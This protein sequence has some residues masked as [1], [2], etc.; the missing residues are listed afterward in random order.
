MLMALWS[1]CNHQDRYQSTVEQPATTPPTMVATVV[2][3]NPLQL[4]D[5]YR[6]VTEAA[7]L[8]ESTGARLAEDFQI[9]LGTASSPAEQ[10][11]N[12]LIYKN[13]FQGAVDD[14]VGSLESLPPP[15]ESALA[16]ERLIAS[17]E[18]V[19]DHLASLPTEQGWSSEEEKDRWQRTFDELLGRLDMACYGAL[20]SVNTDKTPTFCW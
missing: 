3:P 10:F 6:Q 18:E 11:S 15:A 9:A 2:E 12:F 8:F 14:F 20:Q 5:Y 13:G 1:A 19:R 16:H 17:L 4:D 7:G